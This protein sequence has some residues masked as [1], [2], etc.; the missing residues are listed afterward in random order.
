MGTEFD[1][2]NTKQQTE[3]FAFV[4]AGVQQMKTGGSQELTGSPVWPT[5]CV[6][7]Q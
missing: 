5:W 3:W 6:P 7:S 2:Q 4:A 1:F